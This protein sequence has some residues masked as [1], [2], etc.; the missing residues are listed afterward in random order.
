MWP[1]EAKFKERRKGAVGGVVFFFFGPVPYLTGLLHPGS[2]LV[3]RYELGSK[4][5]P[6]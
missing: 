5:N 3:A 1:Q 6:A 4:Q 2:I